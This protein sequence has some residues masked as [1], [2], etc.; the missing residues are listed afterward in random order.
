ML[1][2]V[3]IPSFNEGDKLRLTVESLL[4]N[5]TGPVEIIVV[6]NGS[7]DH[8]SDFLLGDHD[9]RV[10]LVHSEERLGVVGARHAGA[11]RAQ[12][13]ILVFSD[14]HMLY[15]EG[16]LEP[17]LAELVGDV[18]LVGPGITIWGEPDG[19]CAAGSTWTDM[20]LDAVP[21]V[22][23]DNNPTD[24]G[25]VGGGCHVFRRELFEQLG[26][27]DE[28][29]V[30]WGMEDQELCVRL[31][32]LGHRVRVVPAVRVQHY[33]REFVAYASWPHVTYNKLR[34]AFAHFSEARITR[35]IQALSGEPCFSE[36]FARVE[37]SDV[38]DRRVTLDDKR[39]RDAEW[40]CH[41][42]APGV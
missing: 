25:V 22:S 35:C 24:V 29:M 41:T 30:D 31:W 23:D 42:F 12:G 2:S 40:Y 3:V 6:D 4:L 32:T 7:T 36:A 21:L 38:W 37:S 17:L 9:P 26:G 27:Y 16:W 1:T 18:G 5:T 39:L 15:P 33:F 14:A 13:E 10:T 28:G 11:A 19:A 20:R 34:L 8:S